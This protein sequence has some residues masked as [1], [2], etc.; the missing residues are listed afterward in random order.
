MKTNNLKWVYLFT[1][2]VIW[3]SSFILIKKSLLGLTPMQLGVLR[4]LITSLILL[5]L[6]FRGLK[7]VTLNEWK[8]LAVSG[9]VGSFVPAFLFAIAETEIDSA[10]TSVLNSLVPMHT[11]WL[12][13]TFFNIPSSKRQFLGLVVGFIGSC[14]LMLNGAELNPNQNYWYAGFI[15]LSGLMYGLNV[16]IIKRYLHNVKP[17]TIAAGNYTIIFFPA[18][19]MLFFVD[20]FSRETF[21][22]PEF[23][24]SMIYITTLSFFGT[25]MAKILFNKLVKISTPVFTSSVTYVMP[26]VALMWGFLDGERF[27]FTQAVA[28]FVILLGVFLVHKRE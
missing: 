19:I 17:L 26:I 23:G 21:A 10:V 28:G 16:N 5:T 11:F 6:G 18:V 27:S 22:N 2:S 20:F 13:L 1:L 8:W 4:N 7:T 9:L 12:G 25:A 3:G 15:L 24:M 14:V